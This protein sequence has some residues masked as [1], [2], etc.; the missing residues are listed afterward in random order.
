MLQQNAGKDATD[1]FESFFHS[2]FARDETKKYVIGKV[3]GEELGDL[4]AGV[5]EK[6][7]HE[8]LN[9]GLTGRMTIFVGI[10]AVIILRVLIIYFK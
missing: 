3:K 4:H 1:K 5:T 9:T 2:N 8:P 10:L 7:K 6:R